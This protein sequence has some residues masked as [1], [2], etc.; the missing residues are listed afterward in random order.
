MI[1]RDSLLTR[2]Q[3]LQSSESVQERRAADP[4]QQQHPGETGHTSSGQA[5]GRN[6]NTS[7]G[8]ATGLI[9]REE[10]LLMY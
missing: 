6:H 2:L 9:L 3:C 7:Q 4:L 10:G 8:S 1:L 5:G